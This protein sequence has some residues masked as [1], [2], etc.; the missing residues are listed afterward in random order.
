L[1]VVNIISIIKQAKIALKKCLGRLQIR[2][3]FGDPLPPSSGK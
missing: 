1:K 2:F 3:G